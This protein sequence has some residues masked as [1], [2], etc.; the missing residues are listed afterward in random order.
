[1]FVEVLRFPCPWCKTPMREIDD[2]GGVQCERC[3]ARSLPLVARKAIA[4]PHK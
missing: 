4:R 2:D 1:L 3:G